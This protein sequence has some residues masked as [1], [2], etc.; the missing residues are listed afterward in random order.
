M[1]LNGCL[2]ENFS[3]MKESKC[4]VTTAAFLGNVDPADLKVGVNVQSK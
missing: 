3:E 4:S 2:H 1:L